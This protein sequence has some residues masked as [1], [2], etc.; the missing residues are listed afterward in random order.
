MFKFYARLADMESKN[1]TKSKLLKSA[2]VEDKKTIPK[3]KYMLGTTLTS[4]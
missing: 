3:Q 1:E 4:T 2:F